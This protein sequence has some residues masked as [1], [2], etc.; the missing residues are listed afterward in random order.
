[1][2]ARFKSYSFYLQQKTTVIFMCHTML[3]IYQPQKIWHFLFVTDNSDTV[4]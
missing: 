1:M 4:S 3:V 2:H